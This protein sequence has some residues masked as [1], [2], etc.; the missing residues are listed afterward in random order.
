M[1]LSKYKLL[2]KNVIVVDRSKKNTIQLMQLMSWD[3]G[4]F[5]QSG[6]FIEEVFPLPVYRAFYKKNNNSYFSPENWHN[7]EIFPIFFPRE[8]QI[9]TV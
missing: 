9:P 1:F 6:S 5:T 7:L 8:P 4:R 2:I 3:L